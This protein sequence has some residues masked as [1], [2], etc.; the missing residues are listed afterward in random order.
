MA[1]STNLSARRSG[2]LD[3]DT[4]LL[5]AVGPGTRGRAAATRTGAAMMLTTRL[6]DYDVVK[7]KLYGA[8]ANVAGGYLVQVAS[9]AEGAAIGTASTYATV[10]VIEGSGI[11]TREVAVSGVQIE[12]AVRTAGSLTG[13]VRCVAIR[14][15]A[16]TG[17]NGAAVP[18]GTMTVSAEPVNMT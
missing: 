16:G 1:R 4:I 10:A 8:T 12:N 3:A 9:V 15:T 6:D 17:A 7:F 13:D 5:G 11:A 2:T 14:L 18:A